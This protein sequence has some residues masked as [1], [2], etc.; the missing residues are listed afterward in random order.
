[1][2]CLILPGKSW[3]R[4]MELSHDSVIPAHCSPYILKTLDN[5]SYNLKNSCMRQSCHS[6]YIILN[7]ISQGWIQLFFERFKI[8]VLEVQAQENFRAISFMLCRNASSCG[9]IRLGI[10]W[11]YQSSI[12]RDDLV[13]LRGKLVQTKNLVYTNAPVPLVWTHHGCLN[14]QPTTKIEYLLAECKV[15]MRK[16]LVEVFVYIDRMTK[17]R[18]IRE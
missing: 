6:V 16:Y 15:H 13:F 2:I 1:M 14:S 7:V 10:K 3:S 4:C 9:E 18:L 17:A 12:W 5:E 8:E 11:S